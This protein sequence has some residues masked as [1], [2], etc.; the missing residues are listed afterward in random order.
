MNRAKSCGAKSNV[1]TYCIVG[2]PDGKEWEIKS[3]IIFEKYI[4]FY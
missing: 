3:K 1:P 4:D 2:F